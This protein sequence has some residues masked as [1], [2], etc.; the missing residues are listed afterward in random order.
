M[1]EATVAEAAASPLMPPPAAGAYLGGI[2]VA[3]LAVWR[4][5]GRVHLPFVR[6]GGKVMYRRIDLDAF[7]QSNLHGAAA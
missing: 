6:V 1:M 2:P 5:T 7:I 4:S 3:T